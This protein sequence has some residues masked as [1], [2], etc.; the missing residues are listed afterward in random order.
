MVC[1]NRGSKAFLIWAITPSRKLGWAM[2][3]QGTSE[4]RSG[5]PVTL[6][7]TSLISHE[8]AS[9][10][11]ADHCLTDIEYFAHMWRLPISWGLNVEATTP[12]NYILSGIHDPQDTHS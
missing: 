11:N 2:I 7:I 3:N 8:G 12:E 6:F 1:L 10:A 4:L 5:A 9:L